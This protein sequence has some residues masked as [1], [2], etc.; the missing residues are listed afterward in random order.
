MIKK[1]V[2]YTLLAI[3]PFF[4]TGCSLKRSTG[5]SSADQTLTIWRQPLNKKLDD[6]VFPSIIAAYKK[7]HPNITI[8]YKSFD[9]SEDYET[10][11]LNALAAGQGP[12]IWEIRNDELP[13][14]KDKLISL[15]SQKVIK[16]EDFKKVYAS[17]IADEMV[18]DGK[19]YGMPLGLDPLVL[20]MNKEHLDEAKITSAPK[21]WEEMLTMATT[22]TRKVNSS[23]FRPGLAMGTATNINHAGSIVELLMQ[24]FKTQMVDPG[25]RTATFDLYTQDPSGQS[26][27]YPGQNAVQFY[28][29]FANPASGYQT[30]DAE[31][32]YST[33]AFAD[34]RVSMIIDYL[35]VGPQLKQINPKLDFTMAY[36]PQRVV[37]AFPQGDLPGTVS[38]PVYTARYRALVVSKP[39]AKLSAS[40]QTAKQELAWQFISETTS[41]T[42][43]AALNKKTWAISPLVPAVTATTSTDVAGNTTTTQAITP[44]ISTWYKGPSPRS[45]D[46][47][48][49]DMTAAITEGNLPIADTMTQAA[50]VISGLLQ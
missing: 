7:K 45:V 14:H 47:I 40:Q 38:D 2:S 19:L 32:P 34:G 35:S 28:S 3:V 9:A 49:N 20:Y 33:Q 23:I 50:K 25:H 31:Q 8:V 43:S 12:D 22:L 46:K 44:Y 13:R 15:P 21:T 27:D 39:W 16:V 5:T 6:Q 36:V 11:V 24:Q 42:A 41:S 10:A 18:S 4:L 30:W 37:R 1:L 26:F 29:G 17:S 48:M